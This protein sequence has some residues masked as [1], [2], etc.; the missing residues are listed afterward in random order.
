MQLLNRTS[1]SFVKLEQNRPRL[2]HKGTLTDCGRMITSIIH[3]TESQ[4][5]QLVGLCKT[6][7]FLKFLDPDHIRGLKQL[8]LKRALLS[9]VFCLMR[10]KGK[11][12]PN[13]ANGPAEKTATLKSKIM[14]ANMLHFEANVS[15]LNLQPH[16]VC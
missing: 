15:Y 11:K 14:K 12:N 3:L 7:I 5:I 10:F 13:P 16:S 9:Y 6:W 8:G 4:K 1:Y 2:S